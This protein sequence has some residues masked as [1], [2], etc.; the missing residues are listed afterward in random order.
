M[1]TPTKGVLNFCLDKVSLGRC[2]GTTFQQDDDMYL[3]RLFDIYKNMSPW[4]E[5][6][7]HGMQT[8]AVLFLEETVVDISRFN[9]GSIEFLELDGGSGLVEKKEDSFIADG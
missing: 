1:L 3:D 5:S 4:A 9:E 2:S 6:H 7:R 8:V